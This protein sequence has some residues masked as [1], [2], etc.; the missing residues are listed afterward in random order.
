MEM[1]KGSWARPTAWRSIENKDSSVLSIGGGSR[2]SKS[3]APRSPF[4]SGKILRRSRIGDRWKQH[5]VEIARVLDVESGFFEE[6]CERTAP[7][8]PLVLAHHI[9]P[10]VQEH[11]RGHGDEK[12]SLGRQHSMNLLQNQIVAVDVLEHVED[13]HRVEG[14]VGKRERESVSL[15]R[16]RKLG[17]VGVDR[18]SVDGNE[19]CPLRQHFCF[20]HR[21][22][23]DRQ[24]S[25]GVT[26][27]A[28]DG[29]FEDRPAGTVPPM[30]VLEL[31]HRLTKVFLHANQKV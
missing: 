5:G 2:I 25:S 22:Y 9:L 19:A 3:L 23:A 27:E 26:D 21:A 7:V 4:L 29:L 28:I 13:E 15:G 1:P 6:T 10:A 17:A 31:G 30:L 14:V 18:R 20:A 12:P 24:G 11:E 16:E 8:A